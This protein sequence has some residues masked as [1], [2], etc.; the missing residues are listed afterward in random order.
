MDTFTKNGYTGNSDYITEEPDGLDKLVTT[1][2]IDLR[3]ADATSSAFE[4]AITAGSRQI[5]DSFGKPSLMLSS[6]MAMEDIQ[7]LLRDR[8]RVPSGVTDAGSN[9]FN[10]YPTK[11][12]KPVLEDNVFIKEGDVPATSS[13]TSLNPT[14]PTINSQT[15]STATSNFVAAT[16]R[17]YWYKIVAVNKYGDSAATAAGSATAIAAGEINTISVTEGEFRRPGARP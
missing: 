14:A 10:S 4:D 2:V 15:T 7:K 11:F 17:N 6:T 12:G 13:L 8:I 3:G 1:N 9:V 5:R 16:A